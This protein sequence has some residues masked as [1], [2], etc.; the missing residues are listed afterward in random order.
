MTL[1]NFSDL[2][3]INITKITHGPQGKRWE[4]RN[5]ITRGPQIKLPQNLRITLF[6]NGLEVC[7]CTRTRG[8]GSGTGRCLTGRVGYGYEVHGSGIPVFTRTERYFSR[9]SSYIECFFS[10]FLLANVNSCSR[11]LY[12]V[13]R[14]SVV[15]R[16]SSVVCR[17][18]VVCL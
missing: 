4:S 14:P 17:L 18:S 10:S 6:R 3:K 8:Y 16:L 11:S 2:K 12:V 9:C 5:A 13:V 15:C 1:N 7:G